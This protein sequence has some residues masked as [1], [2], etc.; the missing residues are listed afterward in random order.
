MIASEIKLRHWPSQHEQVDSK[1]YRTEGDWRDRTVVDGLNEL[2]RSRPEDICI[3]DDRNRV[4]YRQLDFEAR[5]LAAHF[6]QWGLCK[7]DVISFQLPNWYEVAV[8]NTAAA[9][10]G[11][12]CNPI[13]PIYRQQ[14]VQYI[15][16][17]A[18]TRV[19]FVP[20]T[21]RKFDYAAMIKSMRSGLPSLE[22]V[23][24]V[25]GGGGDLSFSELVADGT[26]YTGK[27][28]I[29]PDD[30]KLLMYTSGT[31]G[32]PKGVVHSSNTLDAEL[33]SV[34]NFWSL[35]SRDVCLMPSPVT[36]ITG[37]LYGIE[38]PF[39][40]G[41]MAVLMEQRDPVLAVEIIQEQRATFTVG[42]TPFLQ[43]L[44]DV[45]ENHGK[46]LD[47]FRFFGC[48]GASVPPELVHRAFRVLP[49]TVVCRIYGSTEAP[50]V[51]LGV[52]SRDAENLAADT[53]GRIV[54]HEVRILGDKGESLPDGIEGE[55]ATRGPE[56]MLG[57]LNADDTTK[58]FSG[59]GFFHTG[60]I[61]YRTPDSHIVITGR[62]KD[63]IIRG[64]ENLSVREIE[65]ALF[66]YPGVQ[67]VAVVPM[68][69]ERLG[70]TACAYVRVDPGVEI[71]VALAAAFL[72][73]RGL[74]KQKYPERIEIVDDLPRTASGK[75]QK[76]RLRDDIKRRLMGINE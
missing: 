73:E 7:G 69:H 31:T 51:S 22:R 10:V 19:M 61:G 53:D 50:T 49:N 39:V 12:V 43:E 24:T 4:S 25:R 37:Y 5:R 46:A 14:E 6:E 67:E 62:R 18:A 48:G 75:I 42:A 29:N 71:D 30:P 41:I 72:C 9:L 45:V 40:Y 21:Y 16:N 52:A 11:A 28:R 55:I 35:S 1:R 13:V 3:T 58:A 23:I 38:F 70:E 36:H 56:V 57:Y 44:V 66:E 60:D 27:A 54:G 59:D 2:L 20:E 74:A 63:L 32:R 47:S 68:P 15:L 33:G 76:Y 34:V 26:T 64:G 17:D 8:I 65:D